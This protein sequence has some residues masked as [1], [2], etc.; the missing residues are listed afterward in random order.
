MQTSETASEPQVPMPGAP[1][2]SGAA[3]DTRMP[4]AVRFTLLTLA[5]LVLAGAAYLLTVRGNAL[6]IDLSV[7]GGKVLCF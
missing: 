5:T 3:P 6:M 2:P 7:I 1:T 4:G